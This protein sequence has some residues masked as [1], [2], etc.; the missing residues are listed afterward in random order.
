MHLEVINVCV[1]AKARLKI[2]NSLHA[3]H[4]KSLQTYS[5]VWFLFRLMVTLSCNLLILGRTD[6]L[7]ELKRKTTQT[8]LQC[9]RENVFFYISPSSHDRNFASFHAEICLN[10][11]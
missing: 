4:I 9:S 11:L 7:S 10:I 6:D 1:I 5:H 8:T 2:F 3:S